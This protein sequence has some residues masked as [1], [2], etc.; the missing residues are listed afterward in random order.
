[1]LEMLEEEHSCV[2]QTQAPYGLSASLVA[3]SFN[4][5]YFE[6]ENY[7]KTLQVLL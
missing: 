2:M 6:G 5:L 4:H 3:F 7:A 1:M